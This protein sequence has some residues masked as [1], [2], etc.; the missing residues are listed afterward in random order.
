MKT[1][2]ILRHAKSDW[3]N[4]KLSD[5]DRP[6]NDRGKYDAPRMGAWLKLKKMV[7]EL[8][9]SSTAERALTTAELVA[10]AC[11]FEGELRTER[12]FYLAGPPTYVEILNELP[13]SYERVMV[14]GHNPGMEELVSLLTDSDRPMSTANVAVVEL[15]IDSWA[16][17]TVFANGRLR[18]HWQPRDLP[19]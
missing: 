15:S 7:P 5:H 17:L 14:V 3:G 16:E 19:T 4:S 11:D 18:H 6:L 2:L 13:D 12:H 1:L 9:I 8:I 10:L